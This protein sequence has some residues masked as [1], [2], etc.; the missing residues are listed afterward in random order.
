MAQQQNTHILSD[1][2]CT[3][4]YQ[5]VKG[6]VWL[7]DFNVI[8]GIQN[9]GFYQ[10][11]HWRTSFDLPKLGNIVTFDN[12]YIYGHEVNKQD[13]LSKKNINYVLFSEYIFGRMHIQESTHIFC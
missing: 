9:A 1:A 3:Q 5:F 4:K 7:A 13:I 12:V 11:L 8:S 6:P 10:C 2:Y